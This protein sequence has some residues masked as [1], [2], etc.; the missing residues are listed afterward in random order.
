MEDLEELIQFKARVAKLIVTTRGQAENLLEE[1]ED[2]RFRLIGLGEDLPGAINELK[3]LLAPFQVLTS[4]ED[5]TKLDYIWDLLDETRQQ[6]LRREVNELLF[7]WMVQVETSVH[8][9]AEPATAAGIASDPATLRQALN[10]CDRVLTFAEPREPWLAL[11]A[12]LQ[13]Q[14]RM[15][16][17][18]DGIGPAARNSAWSTPKTLNGEPVHVGNEKSALACF[19]WGLLCSSQGLAEGARSSGCS[20]LSGSTGAITGISSTWPTCWA[21]RDWPTRRWTTIARWWR[22]SRTR[23]GCGSIA[24]GFLPG[25]WPMVLGPR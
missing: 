22:A 15:G 23:P 11:R 8:K 16:P 20:R 17:A 5:W 25:Q 19:Q 7:L 4:K 2:L 9:L 6:R 24:P 12:L 1:S 10:V 14:G 21:R 13:E 3:W 18:R